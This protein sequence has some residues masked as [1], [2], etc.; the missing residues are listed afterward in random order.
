VMTLVDSTVSGNS[1]FDAGGIANGG[2]MTLVDSTVSGNRAAV[3]GGGISNFEALTLTSSTVSGNSAGARGGGLFASCSES[4][5]VTNSTVSGNSAG[6]TGGGIFT[7]CGE[8]TSV[9]SSTVSGNSAGVSG[10]GLSVERSAATLV[11]TIVAGQTSGGNCAG[12]VSDGGYNLDDG[13]SCGFSSANHS[14]SSTNPLLDPAGLKSNGGPTQTI[15]LAVGSPALDAIPAGVN[16][17]GTTLT[18]DQRGVTR[19]QGPGCDIGAFELEENAAQLLAELAQAVKGVGPGTSLADKVTQ[20]QHYLNSNDVRS[21]CSTL[22]AFVHEVRAQ[23]GK[24]IKPLLADD[25]IARAQ[26]IE[27]LLRC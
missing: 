15:A 27:T 3:D 19:P 14:L 6:V 11:D 13:T 1:A 17:C 23:K 18:T 16:G 9:S 2:V 5:R 25:L 26:R 10:G 7:A 12:S 4:T 8:S 22:N 20:A 21:A 24:T